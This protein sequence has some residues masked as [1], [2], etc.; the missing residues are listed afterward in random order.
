VDLVVDVAGP[1]HVVLGEREVRA[2]LR[3]GVTVPAYD[4]EE[5]GARLRA[6]L[7]HEPAVS[8]A[9]LGPAA[10]V[11]ARLTLAVDPAAD[12]GPVA[13][14]VAGRLRAL[15]ATAVLGLDVAASPPGADGPPGHR[16][17]LG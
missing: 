12:P 4:D 7:G 14:R 2:L 11:D 9:W 13:Q 15:A 3:P 16:P 8:A 1:V 10:G 5:L 17:L 6:V